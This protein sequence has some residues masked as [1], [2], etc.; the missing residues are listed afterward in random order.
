MENKFKKSG[1]LIVNAGGG[2]GDTNCRC[3]MH[4]YEE[5]L[6]PPEQFNTGGYEDEEEECDILDAG[7]LTNDDFD[8]NIEE[9]LLPID[10]TFKEL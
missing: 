10:I 9:P 2:L 3:E 1:L 8:D 5:P 7:V 4:Q 6:F